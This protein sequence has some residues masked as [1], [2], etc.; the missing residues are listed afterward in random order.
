MQSNPACLTE[1][2]LRNEGKIVIGA[3]RA[4]L[5][6]L[7]ANPRWCMIDGT[8]KIARAGHTWMCKWLRA[9]QAQVCFLFVPTEWGDASPVA[10]MIC[11]STAKAVCFEHFF[12]ELDRECGNTIRDSMEVLQTDMARAFINGAI[13]VCPRLEWAIC[14]VHVHKSGVLALAK[15]GADLQSGSKTA[16]LDL[17]HAICYTCE[18]SEIEGTW[19]RMTRAMAGQTRLLN[20]FA[21]FAPTSPK[22][23][24]RHWAAAYRG[25]G[26]ALAGGKCSNLAEIAHA[27]VGRGFLTMTTHTTGDASKGSY[28]ALFRYCVTLLHATGT[29]DARAKKFTEPA[30]GAWQAHEKGSITERPTDQLTDRP[31]DQ[32][33]RS[34][35]C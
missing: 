9:R 1:V 15:H 35:A 2:Y 6:V 3:T 31:T 10:F 19:K 23:P 7:M 30:N 11:P 28:T 32:P 24:P 27:V 16:I 18:A 17:W 34:L 25:P 5:D 20:H 8:Y 22:F 12:R 13:E 14:T 21:K 26:Y 29:A 4:S 33:L